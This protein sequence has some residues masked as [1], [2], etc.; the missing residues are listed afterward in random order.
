MVGSA[1][2]AVGSI[3]GGLLGGEGGERNVVKEGG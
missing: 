2:G 1:I 3:A